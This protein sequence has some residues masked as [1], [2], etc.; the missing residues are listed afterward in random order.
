MID[1]RVIELTPDIL[2]S[3]RTEKPSR[4]A[5]EGSYSVDNFVLYSPQGS[6]YNLGQWVRLGDQPVDFGRQLPA[7]NLSGNAAVDGA[8]L[9]YEEYGARRFTFPLRLNTD[10]AAHPGTARARDR[11]GQ[12]D[13][14]AYVD[15][16][17]DGVASGY[18]IRFDV[19]T[20]RLVQDGWSVPLQRTGLREGSRGCSST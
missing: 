1:R 17:P 20:G 14:G 9:A 13:P 7:A 19:I 10:P 12:P 15:V 16:Q 2:A 4:L 6:Q 3:D 11:R 18:A 5:R 8:V